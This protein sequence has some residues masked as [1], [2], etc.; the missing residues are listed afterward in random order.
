MDFATLA[1][2]VLC[3]LAIV[4]CGR[5]SS[6]PGTAP[7]SSSEMAPTAEATDDAGI[8]ESLAKLS[9]EDRAAAEKQVVCPVSDAKLG[10]M[11][12]PQK[13]DVKG[14]AVWICC[15]GCKD[16]L[17]EKSDEYLATLKK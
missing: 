7:D 9:P 8:T 14:Q 6:T 13:V 3:G 10:S 15:S 12:P 5:A 2:V 4:G 16:K 17:L 11:G 1:A